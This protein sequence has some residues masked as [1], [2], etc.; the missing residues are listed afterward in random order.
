MVKKG[1]LSFFLHCAPSFTYV[2]SAHKL[3]FRFGPFKFCFKIIVVFFS[4]SPVKN[5]F[6]GYYPF[7][8]IAERRKKTVVYVKHNQFVFRLIENR[9]ERKRTT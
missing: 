3:H 9:S 1:K 8:D 5:S 6:L 7:S 2:V 4:F